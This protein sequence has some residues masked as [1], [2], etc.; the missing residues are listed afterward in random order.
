MKHPGESHS[1]R[2]HELLEEILKVHQRKVRQIYFVTLGTTFFLGV[3]LAIIVTKWL[4]YW[5][6][7]ALAL[8]AGVIC[9]LSIFWLLQGGRWK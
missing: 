6:E 4:P 3:S 8:L 9:S 1:N 5:A 7:V 2:K